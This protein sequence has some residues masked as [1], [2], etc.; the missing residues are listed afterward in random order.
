MH[1]GVHLLSQEATEAYEGAREIVRRFVNA[2]STRE[3]IFTRGTTEAINLV[4]QILGPQP[5]CAP[6]TRS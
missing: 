3:V 2:R 1:R 4:A 6:A 5:A